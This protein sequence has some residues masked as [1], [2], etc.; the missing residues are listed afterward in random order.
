MLLKRVLDQ[1]L[2]LPWPLQEGHICPASSW[3]AKPGMC[4]M[5]SVSSHALLSQI[6]PRSAL[7]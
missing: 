3:A 1:D 5:G 7:I 6:T 2:Q 4:M